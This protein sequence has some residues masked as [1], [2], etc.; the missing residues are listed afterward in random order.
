MFII[1]LLIPAGKSLFFLKLIKNFNFNNFFVETYQ[2]QF[3]YVLFW[4]F[5]T[6]CTM[7]VM[8]FFGHEIVNTPKLTAK[9]AKNE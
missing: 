9:K 6:V 7:A 2:E 8:L 5:A 3:T 4:G 1:S